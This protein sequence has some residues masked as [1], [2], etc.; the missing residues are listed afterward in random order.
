VT[1]MLRYWLTVLAL[2]WALGQPTHERWRRALSLSACPENYAPDHT[3]V[4]FARAD[5]SV[6][7]S[8]LFRH[9]NALRA[10][11]RWQ[12]KQRERPLW[13]LEFEVARNFPVVRYVPP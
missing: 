12:A 8:I 2:L 13:L 7:Y 1:L 9:T 3:L 5:P 4:I 6:S 10:G 11:W